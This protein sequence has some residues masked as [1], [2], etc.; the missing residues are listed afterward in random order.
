MFCVIRLI[1]NMFLAESESAGDPRIPST[2][3]NAGRADRLLPLTRGHLRLHSHK[4]RLQV[5][6]LQSLHPSPGNQGPLE[7]GHHL[8][9]PRLLPLFQK[10]GRPLPPLPSPSSRVW[11][12]CLPLRNKTLPNPQSQKTGTPRQV[13]HRS[14]HP[15]RSISRWRHC[16]LF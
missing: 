13:L 6:H 7:T 2:P 3:I 11:P 10:Y 16:S 5:S 9:R 4:Q 8:R 15:P 1:H 14:G 12:G